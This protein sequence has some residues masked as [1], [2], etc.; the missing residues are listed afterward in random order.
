MDTNIMTPV[1]L[2]DGAIEEIRRLMNEPGFD[3]TQLLR[4]GVKV[5]AAR[6]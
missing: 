4:V 1:T 2:T 3:N 6:E 5:A